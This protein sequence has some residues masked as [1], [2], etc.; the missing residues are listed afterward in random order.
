MDEPPKKITQ[1]YKKEEPSR[2][3]PITEFST[4]CPINSEHTGHKWELCCDHIIMK[5][6]NWWL[7]YIFMYSTVQFHAVLKL[8]IYMYVFSP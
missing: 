1:K 5:I 6:K 4:L 3:K 8:E 2:K 7:M